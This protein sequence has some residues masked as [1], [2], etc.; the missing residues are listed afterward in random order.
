MKTKSLY[1]ICVGCIVVLLVCILYIY[2]KSHGTAEQYLSEP[3]VPIV[4]K[5]RVKPNK[6]SNIPYDVYQCWHTVHIPAG[7]RKTINEN[8]KANPE[9]NFHFYNDAACRKFLYKHF[10]SDVVKAYDALKPSAYK[11]D[12]WRLCIIYKYGGIYMDAKFKIQNPTMF[13]NFIYN[14]ESTFVKDRPYM[15]I[16]NA[17]FYS[18]AGN[19]TL[20]MGINE[21]IDNVNNNDYTMTPLSVTGPEMIGKY[22]YKYEPEAI[23]LSFDEEGENKI[24]TIRDNTTHSIVVNTYSTYRNEQN[25]F[26]NPHYGQLWHQ[27]DI[28][29]IAEGFQSIQTLEHHISHTQEPNGVQDIPFVI[30]QC[31]NR[32]D[33]PD[34]LYQ[35]IKN[36]ASKNPEFDFYFYDDAACR[37]YIQDNFDNDVLNAFDGL[38]PGAFKA[39]LWRLCIIYKRGGVYMDAK[40]KIENPSLFKKYVTNNQSAYVKDRP[41]MAVYN[42]FFCSK[43]GNE[44]LKKGIDTIVENVKTKNYGK[45]VLFVSG[46]EMIGQHV[47][48][49]EPNNI[50]LKFDEEGPNTLGT[51]R[52][53][54][55]NEIVLQ[56]YD[57]YRQEQKSNGSPHYWEMYNKR[58]IYN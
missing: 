6:K 34:G 26:G 15:A 25:L 54:V 43:A 29:N 31:W 48:A 52:D 53:N 18:K 39:D 50:V 56:A 16:Y 42:G 7:M 21:I 33:V 35:T 9:F 47:Y 55:S 45:G 10:S 44:T 41:H 27:K 20:K 38:K 46:P 14:N 57:A 51:I 4:I 1:W 23:K 17:L 13:K 22:V 30:Y 32:Y 2:S 49:L 11:A 36:N 40:F 3:D 8:V 5:A 37:A 58:D 19:E 12:L 24:G 28:Y